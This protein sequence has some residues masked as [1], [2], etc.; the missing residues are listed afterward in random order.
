MSR[1]TALLFSIFFSCALVAQDNRI[2]LIRHDAPQLAY[3]GEH[4]IGVRTLEFVDADRIDVINTTNGYDN[5]YYNRSLT[6]EIWYPAQLK[7]NESAGGQYTTTTRNLNIIA[8]LNGRAVRDANPNTEGDL[9]PLVVIS[10]G[11]PGNRYLMSHLGENLASKGYVVVAIDHRDST[12]EDQQAFASTLYNRPLD[13][14]FVIEAVA[15]LSADPASFL[16][17]L[18]DANTTGVVGFSM[19][20]YGLVNNLGGGYSDA[21][22]ASAQTSPNSLVSAHATGNPDYRDGLDSRIKAGFAIAPWGMRSG[23]WGAEDLAGIDVPTFYLAGDADG[24]SGYENG[25]RAIFKGAINS[26]RY[27]L[28]FKNAGHSAGA[29]YPVPVEI[30]RSGDKTGASHYTDPVWDTLR[31]N[32]IMGHFATAFFDLTLKGD[33]QSK[34]YLDLI[35][36]GADG[37]YSISN[38]QA[39]DDHNYWKGF[40]RGSAVGLKLEHLQLGQ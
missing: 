31:M 26:D 34:T 11:Q 22:A 32:N 28:T 14:R 33:A 24:V 37:V 4:A 17:G 15:Q 9:Y 20:G 3:F 25:T 29:A 6:V 7:E 23:Y 16:H 10:H 19:G 35:P 8:T 13:Q 36:D 2:D 21:I 30:L 5:V 39:N 1:T 38:G 18:V 12:Y 40:Q 27:L